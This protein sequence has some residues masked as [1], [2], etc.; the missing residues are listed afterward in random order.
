MLLLLLEG[1]TT[2]Y[3]L[4]ALENELVISWVSANVSCGGIIPVISF[5]MRATCSFSSVKPE[6]FK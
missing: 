3:A 1:R 5:F 2:L 4:T 6:S